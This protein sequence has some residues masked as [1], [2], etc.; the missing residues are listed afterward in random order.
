MNL[1]PDEGH[2]A[3]VRT[4][5]FFTKGVVYLLI[6][7]LTFLAAFDQ[8]GE[9]SST[10]GAIKYLLTLPMGKILGALIALGL[11]AYTLWRFYEALFLPGKLIRKNNIQNGFRRFRF[12]Y[13]GVFYGIIAY[14]FFK[15][16][17]TS[18]QTGSG[19]NS[20]GNLEEKAA[21]WEL[22]ST[23]WGKLILWILALVVAGQALWQFKIAKDGKFMKKID[24][25]PEIKHEYDFI[26]RSGRFGYISRGVVFGIISFFLIK[27]ILQHNANIYK[28]TEGALQYLLSFSYGSFLLGATA[29]GLI[30]YGIFH[31]MVARHANLTTLQ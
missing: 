10:D 31:I 28:G 16:L 3:K 30:G 1:D 6:G 12:F 2:V 24:N 26:R 18:F 20:D 9:I 5:G 8:G 7:T 23:D 25:Y 17:V 11:S 15:P 22:L 29:L 14:S 4:A 13:S 21:L 27:V 19:G